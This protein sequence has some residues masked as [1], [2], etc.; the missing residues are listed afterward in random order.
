MALQLREAH[1]AVEVGD[2]HRLE[3]R[4][5]QVEM[6]W[7]AVPEEVLAAGDWPSRIE[8]RLTLGEQSWCRCG[9]AERA[10]GRVKGLHGRVRQGW[11]KL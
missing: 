8:V 2:G 9:G 6:E 3:A 10:A 5:G 11:R 1:E 4:C 7:R